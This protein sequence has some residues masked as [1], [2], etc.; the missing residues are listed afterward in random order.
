[1]YLLATTLNNFAEQS[2]TN[3]YTHTHT[4][5]NTHT[6]L[7]PLSSQDMYH[8]ISCSE[9][10]MSRTSLAVQWLGLGTLT[11]VGLGSVPG[12]GTKIL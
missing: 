8:R 4:H 12:W 5:T 1:M 11:A 3:K 7:N 9:Q 2:I 10:F 6:L